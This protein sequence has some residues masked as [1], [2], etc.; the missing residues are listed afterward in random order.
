[1]RSLCRPDARAARGPVCHGLAGVHGSGRW[2]SC[3]VV[4]RFAIAG[5]AGVNRS[6][7][8]ALA[9][10]IRATPRPDHGR[11][12]GR[13]KAGPHVGAAGLCHSQGQRPRRAGQSVW[14]KLRRP[15]DS[16]LASTGCYHQAPPTAAGSGISHGTNGGLTAHGLWSLP[17]PRRG[18]SAASRSPVISSAEE[19]AATSAAPAPGKCRSD[20]AHGSPGARQVGQVLVGLSGAARPAPRFRGSSGA[21]RV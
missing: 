3:P 12:A 20:P 7:H 16:C 14:S 11:Q 18:Q 21:G 2:G 1:M 15:C 4:T 17:T 6:G 13:S 10:L 5:R 9:P 19:M 8:L